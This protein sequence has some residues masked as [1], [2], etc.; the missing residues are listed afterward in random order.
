MLKYDCQMLNSK[1]PML[2]NFE[3]KAKEIVP[4]KTV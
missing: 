3:E 1:I 4:N 2:V